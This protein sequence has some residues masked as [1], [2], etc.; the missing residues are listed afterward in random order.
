M[1]LVSTLFCYISIRTCSLLSVDAFLVSGLGLYQAEVLG[2]KCIDFDDY[3]P[4]AR[5]KIGRAAAISACILVGLSALGGVFPWFLKNSTGQQIWRATKFCHF[6]AL[7]CIGL[8]FVAAS[9]LCEGPDNGF[10]V[11]CSPGLGGFI[12]I[13]NIVLVF[14]LI[15]TSTQY[16]VDDETSRND[17]TETPAAAVDTPVS[18]SQKPKEARYIE[19]GTEETC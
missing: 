3:S 14:A 11:E 10:E 19:E 9:E 8:T 6:V 4:G 7:I 1:S 13:G 5:L 17:D 16:V 2:S 15:M 18:M 12:T